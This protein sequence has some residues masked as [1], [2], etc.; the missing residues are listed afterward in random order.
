MRCRRHRKARPK[1]ARWAIVQD[2]NVPIVLTLLERNCGW[3][4]AC[5]EER[6]RVVVTQ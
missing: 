2:D 6:E 1:R 3:S 4:I 5:S